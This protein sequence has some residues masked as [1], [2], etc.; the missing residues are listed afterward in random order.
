M[1]SRGRLRNLW[2]AM[3]HDDSDSVDFI[4]FAAAVFPELDDKELADT[5]ER[6]PA[7]KAY[8]EETRSKIQGNLNDEEEN[9]RV[10]RASERGGNTPARANQSGA[11][12]A[13]ERRAML[14]S[15]QV[16]AQSARSRS[17]SV[18]RI[19]NLP[20]SSSA[21]RSF[22]GTIRS[23]SNSSGLTISDLSASAKLEQLMRDQDALNNKVEDGLKRQEELQAS[24][25]ELLKCVRLLAGDRESV[26]ERQ[27]T[28]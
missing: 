22:S 28:V 9:E 16:A 3:D 19:P 8:I 2:N 11:A 26:P 27:S 17:S 12:A 13:R 7:A 4:E 21:N 23:T 18:A 1:L 6:N 5:L 25:N 10:L 15:N 24:V 14:R 20:R